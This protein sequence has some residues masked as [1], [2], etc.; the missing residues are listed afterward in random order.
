MC[1]DFFKT[2]NVYTILVV[3]VAGV[4]MLSRKCA[5]DPRKMFQL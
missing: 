2:K 1:F 3:D 5:Q 4:A